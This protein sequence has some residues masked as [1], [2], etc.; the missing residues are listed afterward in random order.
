MPYR[1]SAAQQYYVP[2]VGSV[3]QY[4]SYIDSLPL[5]DDPAVFGMHE[6]ANITYQS[7]ESE[8]II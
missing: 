1:F 7:Q 4:R 5:N 2:K 6:N 8:K 3:E